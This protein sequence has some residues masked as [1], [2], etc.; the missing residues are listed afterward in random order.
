M[1][2]CTNSLSPR[3]HLVNERW[4]GAAGAASRRS[5][6]RN[7][8][9]KVSAFD[10][11]DDM[12]SFAQGRA[13][14]RKLSVDRQCMAAEELLYPDHSFDLIWGRDILHHRQIR[15]TTAELVRVAEPKALVFFDE[16]YTR[17]FLQRIRECPLGAL[18][19]RLVKRTI[20]P[21]GTYTSDDERKLNQSELRQVAADLNNVKIHYFNA[22]IN[23]FIPEENIAAGPF[24]RG[25][26]SAGR[27]TPCEALYRLRPVEK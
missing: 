25:G 19:Y 6:W 23:R 7:M 22:G 4:S 15:R 5:F 9:A 11:S 14:A 10:L 20:Y 24:V 18:L 27:A 2:L 12:F 21:L 17:T 16:V 8:G 13:A 1:G 26:D 3:S